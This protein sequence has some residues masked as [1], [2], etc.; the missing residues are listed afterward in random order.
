[1]MRPTLPNRSQPQ[2]FWNNRE[3]MES[4]LLMSRRLQAFAIIAT[5]MSPAKFL[6]F[7]GNNQQ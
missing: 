6:E 2:D 7:D 4:L 5:F 3:L 1:M